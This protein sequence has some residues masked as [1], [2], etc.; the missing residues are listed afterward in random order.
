VLDSTQF[1]DDQSYLV[2]KKHWLFSGWQQPESCPSTTAAMAAEGGDTSCSPADQSPSAGAALEAEGDQGRTKA[3]LSGGTD[4][5]AVVKLLLAQA[6]AAA[7]EAAAGGHGS[8]LIVQSTQSCTAAAQLRL[9]SQA[10][11]GF[12]DPRQFADLS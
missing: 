3:H 12:I 4:P 10:A 2:D 6:A 7:A 8:A 11:E 5:S 1:V 9:A